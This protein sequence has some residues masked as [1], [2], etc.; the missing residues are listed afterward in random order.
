MRA[1]IAT[2]TVLV[3]LSLLILLPFGIAQG[4]TLLIVWGTLGLV[5][6]V[7]AIAG[8]KLKAGGS[9]R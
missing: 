9:V 2:L 7:A 3:G 6:I 8:R 4:N 1:T 5:L